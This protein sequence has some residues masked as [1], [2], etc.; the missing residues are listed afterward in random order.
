MY[1]NLSVIDYKNVFSLDRSKENTGELPDIFYKYKTISVEHFPKL[2]K[3]I[4]ILKQKKKISR[5]KIFRSY[6]DN[7]TYELPKNFAD[8]K[9]SS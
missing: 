3:D 1:I 4:D 7:K 9:W 6:I 5:N 8:A 2:K